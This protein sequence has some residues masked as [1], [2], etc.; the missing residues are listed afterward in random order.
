MN[1]PAEY[2]M[3]IIDEMKAVEKNWDS[4]DTPEE[5]LFYFSAIFGAINRVMNF[6]TDPILVFAHQVLQ[7]THRAVVVRLNAPKP[8]GQER[9]LGVPEEMID[10]VLSATKDLRS[11]FEKYAL[12]EEADS[13]T[14]NALKKLANI[15]YAATGNGFYLFL[16]GKLQI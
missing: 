16:R 2:M 13:E 4:A 6:H 7:N 15:G 9:I 10:A 5:K 12:Q 1:V 14:W 11:A 8:T 3:L